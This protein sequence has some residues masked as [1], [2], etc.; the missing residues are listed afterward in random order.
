MFCLCKCIDLYVKQKNLGEAFGGSKKN[1]S[2][3]WVSLIRPAPIELP[4][5][6]NEARVDGCSGAI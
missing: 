1:V 5:V 6:R 4:Q 2:L 3:Q